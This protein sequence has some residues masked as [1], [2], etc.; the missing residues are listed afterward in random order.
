MIDG[1]DEI[2]QKDGDTVLATES[3]DAV[4]QDAMNRA[5]DSQDEAQAQ[6][7]TPTVVDL[8][9]GELLLGKRNKGKLS[10]TAQYD[11]DRYRLARPFTRGL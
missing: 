11:T 10:P 3:H 4:S 8:N 9:T 1:F 6:D 7:K 5:P 2:I